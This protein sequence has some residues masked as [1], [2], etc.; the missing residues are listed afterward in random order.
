MLNWI[1]SQ[2]QE[3]QATINSLKQGFAEMQKEAKA[4]AA[5]A[6]AD[7]KTD[8]RSRDPVLRRRNDPTAKLTQKQEYLTAAKQVY[9]DW[10]DEPRTSTVLLGDRRRKAEADET[11]KTKLEQGYEF[12]HKRIAE[13]DAKR[14]EIAANQQQNTPYTG[15]RIITPSGVDVE[16]VGK[17]ANG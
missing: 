9:P 15:R 1:K 13:A 12:M 2:P 7:A 17:G 14:A 4:L 6:R 5:K 10:S 11:L 16:P 3:K 8:V